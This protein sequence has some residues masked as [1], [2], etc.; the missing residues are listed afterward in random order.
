MNQEGCNTSRKITTTCSYDCG[1]RCLLEVDVRNGRVTDIRS[2]SPEGLSIKACPRGLVQKEV[3]YSPDRLKTPLRRT[4]KRGKGEFEPVTWG[5]ALDIVSQKLAGTIESYGT[6]SIFFLAGSGCQSSLNHIGTAAEIFFGL[7]GKCTTVWG[8]ESLEA[9]LQSSLA[10]FGT[11]Y[12]GSTR[13]DILNSKYIILWGWNPR[14]TR[15]G[16]DTYHYLKK[17]RDSGTRII[18]VDP[19]KN[20]TARSIASEWIPIRPGTDAAMLIAM[21]NVIISED[22][23]DHGF[24]DTCTYGFSHFR[25][26]VMGSRDGVQKS[27]RWAEPLCG[28]P[29]EVIETLARDYALKRPAALMTGWAPGRSA[30]GEQFQRAASVLAAITGN[31]GTSGGFVSGG[32]D[33]MDIGRMENKYQAPEVRHNKVHNSDLY[34]CLLKGRKGGYPADCR[35]LYIL[36]YNVLNQY[37]NLNKGIRAFKKQDFIVV[38]ELFMTPTARFADI[39]LPVTHYLERDDIGFPW[40][41]GPYAINMEKAVE[42]G[43]E[44]RSDLEIFAAIAESMGLGDLDRESIGKSLE[45]HLMENIGPVGIDH[46]KD[47]GLYKYSIDLPRIAFS[48]EI[49]DPD[50][51]PFPT[52]SGK[53]EIFSTRFKEMNDPLLP[54]IPEY[55]PAWEGHQDK[56][57]EKY[58]IQLVTTHARLRINSQLDNIGQLDSRREDRIWINTMDAFKRHIADDDAVLVYNDRGQIRARA[59]VT[60]DIMKGVASIDQGKWYMPA[61]DG[62]DNGGNANVLTLDRMSPSG[63]FASNSCLV[64]I[65]KQ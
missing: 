17:A 54:P 47:D 9:A 31:M 61:E 34:D 30:Y 2:G 59:S 39:V 1:G 32:T 28:V 10:T 42:P 14:D 41:G 58:P 19:R 23:L 16:S 46:L 7:L 20:R 55:I 57:A 44:A 22:M 49:K 5:Q 12:T 27:P 3:L 11:R 62:T 18:S 37:L 4:G 65:K 21:A 35:I 6:G 33:M 40:I 45:Q 51:N 36:G 52:P 25:E 50:H 56:R 29:A 43:R 53:I 48:E 60:P 8:G 24:I 26:Y 15:F 63:A 38:H 64:Q 13:D